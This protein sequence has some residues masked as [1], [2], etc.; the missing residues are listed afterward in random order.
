MIKLNINELELP[1]LDIIQANPILIPLHNNKNLIFE[2]P[3]VDKYFTF[4][5]KYLKLIMKYFFMFQNVNFL[6]LKEFKD[7]EV[8]KKFLKKLHKLMQNYKFKKDF[9][10]II[11]VYFKADFKI[12]KIMKIVNPLEF[13]YLFLFIHSIIENVK[14]NFQLV[15]QKMGL[16]MKEIFSTSLKLTSAKIVPRF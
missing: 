3:S 9:G 15:N 14:K 5:A 13:S 2:I 1:V 16:Q 10:K 7:K 6:E 12:R 4:E 8:K 11:K